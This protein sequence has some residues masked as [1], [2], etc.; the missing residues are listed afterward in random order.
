[1]PGVGPK[2]IGIFTGHTD[3]EVND[4]LRRHYLHRDARAEGIK[5]IEAL[6]APTLAVVPARTKTG[7][8]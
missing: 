2:Q 3:A 4:I 1:M 6:F 5:A 8:I 7:A